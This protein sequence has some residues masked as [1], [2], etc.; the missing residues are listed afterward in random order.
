MSALAVPV[1]FIR[2]DFLV[3]RS[4]RIGFLLGIGGTIANAFVFFF[5][6]Q[7][8]GVVGGPVAETYGTDY[9][10]FA[11]IGIAFTQLVA[12]GVGTMGGAVRDG[13]VTGTLE[14]MLVGPT[15]PVVVLLSSGLFAHLNAFVSIALYLVIGVA[16]GLDLGSADLP[17]TLLGVALLIVA[18][19]AIGLLGASVVLLIKQGNPVN[20]LVTGASFILGGV[21]YPTAV[22]PPVLETLASLLPLTPALQIVRRSLLGGAGI[23]DLLPEFGMLIVLTAIYVPIGLGAIAYALRRARIDGSLAEF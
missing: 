3:N 14:L 18:C 21:L 4:Y 12:V 2:R 11:I 10:G 17:A 23:T 15:R 6:S 19:N 7:A 20:W 13:Q 16:L 8:I 22:L 9:F 5:L 1:A